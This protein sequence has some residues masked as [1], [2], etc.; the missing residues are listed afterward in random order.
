MSRNLAAVVLAGLPL[1]AA[2][3]GVLYS[4]RRGSPFKPHTRVAG[5]TIS[6][7]AWRLT[8]GAVYSL[9]C[10]TALS[11]RP[12]AALA[13]LALLVGGAVLGQSLLPA[14]GE[15]IVRG[16]AGLARSPRAEHD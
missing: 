8:L 9:F 1:L 14:G 7:A 16:I 4:T 13:Q 12:N 11:F 5:Q 2:V 6:P 15:I 3:T 10:L